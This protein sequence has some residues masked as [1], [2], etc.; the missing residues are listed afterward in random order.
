MRL[1]WR[2]ITI[3]LVAQSGI[4]LLLGFNYVQHVLWRSPAWPRTVIVAG[5]LLIALFLM[6]WLHVIRTPLLEP[7]DSWYDVGGPGG[8]VCKRTGAMLPPRA[9]IFNG[10]LVLGFDHY[11]G[12]LG[13]PIGLHN[14][15]FFVLLL[16]YGCLLSAFASCLSAYDYHFTRSTGSA[17]DLFSSKGV[18][19][20]LSPA[21]FAYSLWV[22]ID[23]IQITAGQ[24]DRIDLPGLDPAPQLRRRHLQPFMHPVDLP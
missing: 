15:K 22:G 23:G 7:P 18:F 19:M 24:V 20:F 11:C 9:Y 6:S 1:S 16:F 21:A 8:E 14:R 4:C 13:V 17:G 12:W 10:D 5:H 3:A 2:R